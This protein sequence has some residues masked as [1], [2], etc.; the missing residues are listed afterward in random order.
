MKD[1]RATIERAAG[2]VAGGRA[3]DA[4]ALLLGAMRTDAGNPHLMAMLASVLN[5][6]E[7]YEP[8]LYYTGRLLGGG[9]DDSNVY[10]THAGALLG[11][12]R[13]EEAIGAL[14]RA[15]ELDPHSVSARTNLASMLLLTHRPLELESVCRAG[16]D[17]HPGHV[18]LSCD[19][20][21]ALN[22]TGRQE[23]AIEVLGRAIFAHPDS[24][25]EAVSLQCAAA[26]NCPGIDPLRLRRLHENLGRLL[27][28]RAPALPPPE[29]TDP[30]P[31]RRLRV[32]LVSSDLRE[33]SVAYFV[34]PLLEHADASAVEYVAFSTHRKPDATAARL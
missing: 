10:V 34:E 1:H 20:A 9:I 29:I 28:D 24:A 14:H 16:L 19:L 26:N 4:R 31:E 18:A 17:I 23:E 21:G 13:H 33:H 27:L 30:D 3:G 6:L 12:G 11:L 32:G 8:A 7:E 2:L 22:A 15:V 25:L 5:R